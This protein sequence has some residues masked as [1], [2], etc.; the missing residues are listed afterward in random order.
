M[1]DNVPDLIVRGTPAYRRMSVAL[2]VAGFATFA[3]MYDVQP[4]LPLFAAQ[5]GVNAAT[6]SLAVSLTTGT[7]ALAFIPAAVVSDRIGRRSVMVASLFAAAA[8]TVLSA[9]VPGWGQ[10]LGLR[11]A[12]GLALAGLPS[13]AMAYV[14]EEVHPDSIGSAMGLYIAASAIGG[15]AGRLG[16]ASISQYAG[17]RWAIATMGA[18]GLAA[19]AAFAVA[20]PPSRAFVRKQHDLR[21]LTHAMRGH[22]SDKVLPLL[23]V[24]GFLLMGVFVSVYN[25][26]SFRLEAAPYGLSQAAVGLVFLVYLIGSFSSA[27]VGILASRLGP[28]RVL[29]MPIAVLTMGIVLAAVRPLIAVLVG[30]AIVTGAF[31]AAHSTASGWVGRRAIRDRA[32]ASALYLLAYYLG[33]SLLGSASGLAWNSAAWR[34]VTGFV[35]ILTLTALMIAARLKNTLT[36]EECNFASPQCKR[37]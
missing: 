20:A 21:S 12:I 27:W 25:Y 7:M 8:V 5:F 35:L 34:G 28:G 15:M 6:S 17:W 37:K 9:V 10:L 26:I 3:L 31:F 24:E 33:G 32:Q 23:Y 36:S 30:I 18:A 29:W 1:V 11:A 16:T 19:G 14:A 2:L 13:V 4:L 22:L